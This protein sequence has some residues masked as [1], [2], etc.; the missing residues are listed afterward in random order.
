M[1]HCQS[2]CRSIM[3]LLWAANEGRRIDPSAV[4]FSPWAGFPWAMTRSVLRFGEGSCCHFTSYKMWLFWNFGI[5]TYLLKQDCPLEFSTK[6]FADCI[7]I[8]MLPCL[9]SVSCQ[10]VRKKSGL[11]RFR[12]D[13]F[14]LRILYWQSYV[15]PW[16]GTEHW[17]VFL[18]F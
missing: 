9:S 10:R 12:F 18:W 6:A 11:I 13:F 17:A 7:L 15:L 16:R 1:I 4:S 3:L 2:T 8:I 5:E 14:K